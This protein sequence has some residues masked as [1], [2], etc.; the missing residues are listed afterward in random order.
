[1]IY[2]SGKGGVGKSFLSKKICE[3]DKERECL[4]LDQFIVDHFDSCFEI[5]KESKEEKFR[6][7]K[8]DFIK[9][10]KSFFENEEKKYLIEGTIKDKQL[11]IDLFEGFQY[12]FLYVRPE[13]EKLYK[14]SIR[15][16]FKE[17]LKENK[18]TLGF[19]WNQIDPKNEEES[20][21][22]K[23]DQIVEMEFQKV[24]EYENFYTGIKFERVYN[25]FQN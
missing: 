21:E 5:Y 12:K 20:F 2:I 7:L 18:K 19:V 17:D 11:V 22:E 13:S 6:C 23:I 16:R 9:K 1:M 4:N 15:R 24:D 3:I 25:N 10:I 8:I 14:E